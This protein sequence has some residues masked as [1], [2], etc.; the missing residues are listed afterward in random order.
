MTSGKALKVRND[1]SSVLY[2]SSYDFKN[3]GFLIFS[4]PFAQQCCSFS[5]NRLSGRCI[6]M[7]G[8][9]VSG[10]SENLVHKKLQM[11][12]WGGK[13]QSSQEHVHFQREN[14]SQVL[15]AK[16]SKSSK[17]TVLAELACVSVKI[18]P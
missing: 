3:E 6:G 11:H 4:F 16:L 14:F 10:L 1:L 8:V 2:Q 12:A 9:S 18:D 15:P 17:N 7:G 5:L 13:R